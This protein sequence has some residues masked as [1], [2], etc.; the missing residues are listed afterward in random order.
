MLLLVR[1]RGLLMRLKGSSWGLGVPGGSL[2]AP[3]WGNT[4]LLMEGRVSWW[5]LEDNWWETSDGG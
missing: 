3:D 2:G 5:G 1:D 4:R